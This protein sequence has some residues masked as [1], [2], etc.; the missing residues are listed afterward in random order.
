MLTSVRS[1]HKDDVLMMIQNMSSSNLSELNNHVNDLLYLDV[2]S[3]YARSMCEK[4]PYGKIVKLT[5]ASAEYAFSLIQEDKIDFKNSDIGYYFE[6]SLKENDKEVQDLT[7][8]FPMAILNRKIRH[9]QVSKF[10]KDNA[11]PYSK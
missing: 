5:E 8:E 6:V 10:M 1:Y 9:T 3:N 2:D 11:S 4:I 7:D